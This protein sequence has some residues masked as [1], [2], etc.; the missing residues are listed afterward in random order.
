[1]IT[2]TTPVAIPNATR[3]EVADVQFD[4][5]QS[6]A[7]V[8]LRLRTPPAT[9][10]PGPAIV[11]YIADGA[12]TP[13]TASMKIARAGSPSGIHNAATVVTQVNI[14]NGFTSLRTAWYAASPST[15]AARRRA[16]ETQGL[17]DGWIDASLTG[18]V[19]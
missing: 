10:L 3:L 16:A 9:D 19:A 8:T 2:L 18:S 14:V 11:L 4:E 17:A 1:M 13:Q 12:G 5:D 7:T 15:K 6:I